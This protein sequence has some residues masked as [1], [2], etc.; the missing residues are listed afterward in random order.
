MASKLIYLSLYY[1]LTK[2]ITAIQDQRQNASI[3]FI[4]NI[5]LMCL[6]F[7]RL[8]IDLIEIDER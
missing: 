3:D 1:K 2:M 8:S 4:V 6:A 7:G 5:V